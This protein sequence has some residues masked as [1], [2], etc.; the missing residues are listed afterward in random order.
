MIETK[1]FDVADYLESDEQIGWFLTDAAS[2]GE[3]PFFAHAL[4]TAARAKGM[5][6]I[7]RA[8]GLSR[9]SLYKALSMEGNPEF[10]TVLKVIDALGLQLAV[11]PK[12]PPP[13]AEDD[14]QTEG[15]APA[16]AMS[17]PAR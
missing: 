8:T 10:A 6:Q 17:S 5:T 14:D 11:V 13:P 9:E 7:A 1:P 15:E 3:A 16:D 4:G 12:A 2:F